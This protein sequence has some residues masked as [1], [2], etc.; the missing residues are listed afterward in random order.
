MNNQENIV[1]RFTNM[2]FNKSLNVQKK[3][4]NLNITGRVQSVWFRPYSK[5]KANEFGVK[6]YIQHTL[7]GLYVEIEGSEEALN[8]FIEWCK[9]GP[10]LAR[11]E[12]IEIEEG[13]IK[14]FKKFV[15]G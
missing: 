6:G 1:Q 5:R 15:I 3:H 4:Y 12:S 13:E 11:V 2:F 7:E 8:A 9:E 10:P 14:G